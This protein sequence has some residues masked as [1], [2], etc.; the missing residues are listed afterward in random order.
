[1]QSVRLLHR[2]HRLRVRGSINS[3][4]SVRRHSST[5]TATHEAHHE[6][7]LFNPLDWYSRVI[8]SHPLTVKCTTACLV[9]LVGDVAAKKIQRREDIDLAQTAR[10]AGMN[11]VIVG[12]TLH[13]WYMWLAQRFPGNNLMSVAKRVFCDEFIFTPIC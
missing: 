10:F 2:S 1:M 5:E 12:P 13:Y 6:Q 9:S 3:R 4:F 8:D 7:Q 11:L